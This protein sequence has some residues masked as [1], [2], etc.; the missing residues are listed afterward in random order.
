MIF[1]IHLLQA[2][3]GF[4]DITSSFVRFPA[5]SKLIDKIFWRD[6]FPTF[7]SEKIKSRAEQTYK[8][9]ATR[10]E[11]QYLDMNVYFVS[12]DATQKLSML[13]V[14][15]ILFLEFDL[16]LAFFFSYKNSSNSESFN[17]KKQTANQPFSI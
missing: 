17:C 16:I 8:E 2:L 15:M 6:I 11:H 1:L 12:Q 4:R 10:L 3:S 9:W 13:I 7:E 14:I 5:F